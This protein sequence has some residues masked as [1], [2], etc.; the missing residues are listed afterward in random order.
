[1]PFIRTIVSL[2]YVLLFMILSIFTL[3]CEYF[4][5]RK[6]KVKAQQYSQR[7]INWGFA[8][9]TALSGA[10]NTIK[11]SENIPKGDAVLFVANHRSFYDLILG[12]PH[13][14]IPTSI[15]AKESLKKVPFIGAWMKRIGCLFLARDDMRAG[16]KMIMDGITLI[17]SGTSVLIF[18]EGTRNEGDGIQEFHA[19]SFKLAIK[20]GAK[21][22][23]MVITNTREVFEDHFPWLHPQNTCIEFLPP[24][25]TKDLSKEELKTIH[26]KIRQDMLVVFNRNIGS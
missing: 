25:D 7:L 9:L 1:M 10:K 12:Y 6:N 2:A 17:K 18:P 22:V 11:G 5:R 24:V 26:E 23:P 15:V 14:S 4:L 19:G 21:I 16:M 3:P 13:L 20:P 8:C